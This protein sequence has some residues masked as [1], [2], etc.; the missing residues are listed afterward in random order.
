MDGRWIKS[1]TD[2]DGVALL[3]PS[4]P[5]LRRKEARC[6]LPQNPHLKMGANIMI[7]LCIASAE[8]GR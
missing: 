8:A 5:H 7:A 6:R 2:E 4:S 1:S 3:H